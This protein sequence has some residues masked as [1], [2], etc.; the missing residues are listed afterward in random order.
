MSNDWYRGPT[1]LVQ[2]FAYMGSSHRRKVAARHIIDLTW[3]C[4]SPIPVTWGG[5]FTCSNDFYLPSRHPKKKGEAGRRV[6][7]RCRL[8]WPTNSALVYEPK[9]GGRVVA[10]SQPLST[11][12]QKNSP[13]ILCRSNSIFN[14]KGE[15]VITLWVPHM[16]RWSL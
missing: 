15:G 14:L 6:T 4:H 1:E 3:L 2:H 9:Y 8:S 7:K 16:Q 5:Y 13:N 11:A 12:V 10:G